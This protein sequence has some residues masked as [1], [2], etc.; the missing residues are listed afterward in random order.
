MFRFSL[1]DFLIAL[2]D[3][4]Y[5]FSFCTMEYPVGDHFRKDSFFSLGY[6]EGEWLFE[7]FFILIIGEKKYE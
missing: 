4:C 1:F 2:S 3:R 7:L 5:E 6:Y